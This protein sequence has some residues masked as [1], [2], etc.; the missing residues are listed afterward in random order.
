MRDGKRPRGLKGRLWL[1][2]PVVECVPCHWCG[3]LLTYREAT[4]DHEPALA[5]G[6]HPECA[7]LACHACNQERGRE[8]QERIN[9]RRA[10]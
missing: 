7:V 4:V 6:G 8:T 3:V 10:K 1:F 5:E 9:K 2:A